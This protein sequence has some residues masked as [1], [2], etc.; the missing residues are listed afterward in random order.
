MALEIGQKAPDFTLFDS[1][2]NEQSL[3][4]YQGKPVVLLFFPLAFTGVCTAEMCSVR[5]DIASYSGMQAQV[6]GISVDTVFSLAKW[7]EEQGLNFPLLSDFNKE[8]AKA[9]GSYY[10]EFV[11]GMQGVAKRSAFVIDAEGVVQYAEVLESAG[12]IPNLDKVK[13]VLAGLN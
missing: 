2:K 1:D 7:K 12:D 4:S 8:T 6:M 5:D 10:D 3:S 11:M 9:Y 13:E